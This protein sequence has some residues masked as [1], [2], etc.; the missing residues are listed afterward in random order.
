[1]RLVRDLSRAVRQLMTTYHST[2]FHLPWW[3]MPLSGYLLG[4]LLVA[5]V[6]FCIRL[7][8][9]REIYFLWIPFCLATVVVGSLWGVSPA[10]FTTLLA[11]LAFNFLIIPQSDILTLD[12]WSDIRILGPFAL[13]QMGI[14]I[15]AAQSAIKE[16]H[17]QTAR[18]AMHQYAQELQ[19]LNTRLERSNEDLARANQ[20]K[21]EFMTRAAHELRT[22]LTAIL[23]EAQLAQRRLHK[24]VHSLPDL[25]VYQRHFAK[26]EERAHGL[27]T[28]IE[29][30][31]SFSGFRSGK[32][33]LHYTKCD[34][35][36]LCRDVV[37]EQTALLGRTVDLFLPAE[38]LMLEADCERLVLV[39]THLVSNAI[40]YAYADTT[41]DICVRA[42]PGHILF[43]VH[44]TGPALS[45]EQ[46]EHLF[47]P[48][49]RTPYAETQ[50]KEGRGLGLAVSKEIVLRHGGQILVK[51]SPE[52][53][54]TFSVLLPR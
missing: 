28:L 19:V 54:T 51:S 53:G 33:P 48:F 34:F 14:A 23:G 4:V 18:Q 45:Q 5:G 41:I 38:P 3:Q 29:D 12:I 47:E 9:L 42:R 32:A 36:Q 37:A 16:R 39:I 21:E 6:V 13:A 49:Y 27:R 20:L 10:L 22:P 2:F 1:M 8:S 26:I 25:Q 31:I 50:F 35:S 43:Q 7:L 52:K 24:Q 30:L 17:A 11:F 40:H 15:L 46:E 44:N